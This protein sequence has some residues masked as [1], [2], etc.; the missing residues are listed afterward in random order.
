MAVSSP[1]PS[2][3]K[4]PRRAG[5]PDITTNFCISGL[6]LHNA[7]EEGMKKEGKA[8][9]YHRNT[10]ARS[11]TPAPAQDGLRVIP[12]GCNRVMIEV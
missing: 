11:E 10:A 12:G 1:F 6:V 8:P 3:L 2:I 7:A 5:N 9:P 4:E